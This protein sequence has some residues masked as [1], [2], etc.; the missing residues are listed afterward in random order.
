LNSGQPIKLLTIIPELLVRASQLTLDDRTGLL[1]ASFILG[2]ACWNSSVKMVSDLAP[3]ERAELL[4]TFTPYLMK[5]HSAEVA[6]WIKINWK[7]VDD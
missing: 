4:D 7:G 5:L 6:E 3:V 2:G 1:V